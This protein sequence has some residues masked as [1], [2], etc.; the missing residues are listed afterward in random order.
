MRVNYL[1]LSNI[2]SFKYEEDIDNAFKIEFDPDLN[3]IIGENGSGKSTAL[4]AMNFVFTRILFRHCEVDEYKFLLSA[5]NRK[6][7]LEVDD[8]PNCTGFRL[9]SN[10]DS[11]SKSQKIRISTTLDNID[12]TNINHIADNYGHIKKHIGIIFSYKYP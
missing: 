7:A 6:D 12:R 11:D 8:P 1:Q 4:E 5:A 10:W 9:Q 3:I 2:L